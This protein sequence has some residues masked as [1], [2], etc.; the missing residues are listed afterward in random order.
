[1]TA[2][3]LLK[4][5]YGASPPGVVVHQVGLIK[6]IIKRLGQVIL[7][8]S[9]GR[10]IGTYRS[11]MKQSRLKLQHGLRRSSVGGLLGLVRGPGKRVDCGGTG[12]QAT[13]IFEVPCVRPP[14]RSFIFFNGSGA[15]TFRP[16]NAAR[17]TSRSIYLA[18]DNRCA[19]FNAIIPGQ[20]APTRLLF[21]N[22]FKHAAAGAER[23]CG[24]RA[25][26]QTS[27][28]FTCASGFST[29]E[30]HHIRRS[31]RSGPALTAKRMLTLTASRYLLGLSSG[32]A[33]FVGFRYAPI[34]CAGG[35]TRSCCDQ[36]T[37]ASTQATILI[38]AAV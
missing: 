35:P 13:L 36:I 18:G 7:A 14:R 26:K 28:W 33:R 32:A 37:R 20:K 9:G 5:T 2:L 19:G 22:H 8:N 17:F 6:F 24:W 1:M 30:V 16:R 21:G 23:L 25:A 29:P 12:D 3:S 27:G 15:A 31:L 34:I 4:T 11:V 38:H 10:P